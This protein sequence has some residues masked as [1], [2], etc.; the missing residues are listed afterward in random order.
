MICV[1]CNIKMILLEFSKINDTTVYGCPK[2]GLT[3]KSLTRVMIYHHTK[4]IE[5]DGV[6]EVML[7][8]LSEHSQINHRKLLPNISA[9]ELEVISEAAHKRLSN[10]LMLI[11]KKMKRER[12]EQVQSENKKLLSENWK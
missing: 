11:M 10:S 3:Q 6:D 8:T 12:N 5:T 9:K 7:I 1:T 2:C 4:Y